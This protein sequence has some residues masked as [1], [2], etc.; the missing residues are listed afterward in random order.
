M[1]KDFERCVKEGG[2]VRTVSGPNKLFG[3]KKGEYRH[4][5]FL[6]GKSFLGEIKTKKKE[7]E[8]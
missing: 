4:I 6:N 7:G 3:L 8:K 5:C 2:R 1:P